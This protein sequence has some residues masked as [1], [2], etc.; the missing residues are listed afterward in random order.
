HGARPH[1]SVDPVLVAAH[2]TTALQSIVSRNVAAMDTAVLSVTRI[3]T[4]EAYNVI[5][6]KAVMSGTVRA[7][8][9]EVMAMMEQNMRRLTESVATA[10]GAKANLDFDL[11]FAPTVNDRAETD[12]LAEVAIELAGADVVDRQAAPEMGSEDFSFMME[13]VPGAHIFLGNGDTAQLHNDR[14]DFNDAAIPHGVALYA[15]VAEKK[16]PKGA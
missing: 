8:T 1:E 14:Y 16:L 2:L 10:F 12:A 9:R 5:P 7:F 11:R 4:G 3:H 6:E 13:Q 15:L